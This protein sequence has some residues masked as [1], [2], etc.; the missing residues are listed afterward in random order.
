[1]NL[2]K[3][4]ASHLEYVGL[5]LRGED[6]FWGRMPDEPAECICLF[7][8]DAG[9]ADR[10]AR[11]QVVCRSPIPRE[12][13]ETACDIAFELDDYTGFLGGDGAMAGIT[14]ITAGAG[15]GE[16]AHKREMYSTV[17][18]VRVCCCKGVS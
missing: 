3:Q 15:M 13:Y 4:L 5:G 9:G 17:L 14:V 16:D 2:L 10:P 1:M 12:A 11:I 18:A 6:I 8:E 7:C